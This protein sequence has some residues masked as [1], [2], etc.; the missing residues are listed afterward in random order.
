VKRLQEFCYLLFFVAF[1]YGCA[2]IGRPEGGPIDEEPPKFVSA[3]P[4]NYSINFDD[5]EIK[6]QFNEFIK[7]NNPQQQIIFSPPILPKPQISPMGLPAKE[8]KIKLAL[9]SLQRNTTYTINFGQSIEDN[10]E[11]NPLPFFKYIFSTG[12]YLD[13]LKLEGRVNDM[14]NRATPEFV[15]L[16][17]YKKDS[18]YTDSIVFKETPTYIAYAVDSTFN[19]SLENLKAGTYKLIA[20]EDK[21]NDYKFNPG[22]EKIGFVEELIELPTQINYIINIFDTYKDFKPIRPKQVTKNHLIFG[23]DGI[24]DSTDYSIDLLPKASDTFDYRITKRRDKDTLDYW[25]KSYPETDS[26]I[27]SFNHKNE[28]DSLIVK[29]R[30]MENDSLQIETKPR[31]SIGFEEKVYLEANLPIVSVDTT[32]I[33]LIDK[34]SLKVNFKTKL[35]TFQNQLEIEF[36]KE[37]SSVYNMALY[38]DLVKDFYGNTNDTIKFKL[39]TKSKADFSILDL[40]IT[41]LDRYPAIVQIVDDKEKVE[42]SVTLTNTNKHTFEYINPGKY[43]VK[44][45]YD[46]NN[47]GVW[48]SGDYLKKIQPEE[49]KYADID[50]ELRANWDLIKSVRL[51]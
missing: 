5:D 21:N 8:V 2:K 14:F 45:I 31:S 32:K 44:V 37:E 30:D 24:L 48:D 36:E 12:N 3:N 51:E 17:L 18:T 9:D 28:S 13:S 11:G 42:K 7:L 41:N 4:E 15:S 49:V 43:F 10:N 1:L 47:N 6:I 27:F 33:E 26:L 46:D 35:N 38:P 25:F 29:I 50:E 40:T 20:L 19:F 22:R 16:M 39:R 23:Y 34:D